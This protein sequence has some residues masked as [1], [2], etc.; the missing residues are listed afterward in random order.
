MT[1]NE[2]KQYRSICAEI[3]ELKLEMNRLTLTDTVTGSDAEFPYTKH[4]M[5]IRGVDDDTKARISR[6]I[7]LLKN[8]RHMIEC[9]VDAID[10]SI[11]RRIFKY[12]YIKDTVMPSWRSVSRKVGGGMSESGVRMTAYRYLKENG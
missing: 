12:R 11:T 6:R 1:E 5:S 10:D 4:T 9:Y 8:K 7:T 2:L 3:E